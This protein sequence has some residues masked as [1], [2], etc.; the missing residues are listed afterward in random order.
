MPKLKVEGPRQLQ[1]QIFQ[2]CSSSSNLKD[3]FNFKDKFMTSKLR[4][5]SLIFND[6]CKV[7]DQD[8]D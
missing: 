6:S 5:D 7:V 3:Y 8:S 4:L 1:S 2:A